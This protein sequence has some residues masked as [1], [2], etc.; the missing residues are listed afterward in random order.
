M[1]A[2]LPADAAPSLDTLGDDELVHIFSRLPL[3]E[4][5]RASAVS[6]R[7]R[8][9][10]CS[11]LQLWSTVS[12]KGVLLRHHPGAVGGDVALLA[13]SHESPSIR[14]LRLMFSRQGA[15]GGALGAEGDASTRPLAFSALERVCRLAGEKLKTLD[16][17]E[18][19]GERK[20]WLFPKTDSP[21]VEKESVGHALRQ[22][23]HYASAATKLLRGGLVGRLLEREPASTLGGPCLRAQRSRTPPPC[24]CRF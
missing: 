2:S 11:S 21:H 19:T 10:L 6:R 1:E 14:A 5:L 16:V 17:C 4:R 20:T 3:D 7:F 24:A 18:A 13:I 15:R 22:M 23:A 9:L 12:F 8:E